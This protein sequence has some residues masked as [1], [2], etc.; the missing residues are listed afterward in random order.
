MLG[1]WELMAFF[2]FMGWSMF[3]TWGAFMHA[4][5]VVDMVNARGMAAAKGKFGGVAT[6]TEGIKFFTLLMI[7]AV[8]VWVAAA[9]LGGNVDEL[10]GFFDK[11]DDEVDKTTTDKTTGDLE[12]YGVSLVHDLI[13]HGVTTVYAWTVYT[14][15]MM[16]GYYFT[17]YFAKFH[18]VSET[19]DVDGYE[20][21]KYS[22]INA[23]L[24]SI[25][26]GSLAECKAVMATI[27]EAL[28][29]NN[30]KMLDRCEDAKFLMFANN[31]DKEYAT[32]FAGEATLPSLQAFCHTLVIDAFDQPEETDQFWMQNI[33]SRVAGVFPFN[34]LF[35]TEDR[36]VVYWLK[37]KDDAHDH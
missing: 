34:F 22:S 18:P 1:L 3:V 37:D 31:G 23:S 21:S 32:N 10:V 30:D 13:Y 5:H 11:Y 33:L 27:F 9:S 12:N 28:D 24:A 7:Q 36:G 8:T 26:N 35:F 16:A 6:M 19:C 14:F 17:Y 20:T 25:P 4:S 29:L 2:M 15:I